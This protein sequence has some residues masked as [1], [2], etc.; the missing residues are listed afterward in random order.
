MDQPKKK[1]KVKVKITKSS[2]AFNITDYDDNAR[3]LIGWPGYRTA[4][5]KS[6]LGYVETQAEWA[7][8]QGVMIR[9]MMTGK[10]RTHNPFYLL[11]MTLIGVLYGGIPVLLIFHEVFVGGNWSILVLLVAAF[12]NIAIGI[13]LLINVVLSIVDRNG[14][15]VTRD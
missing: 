2:Y 12:P 8:M 1:P 11:G 10:F 6:G 7:H 4:N 3:F 14:K 13:L 9:W 15:T 5:N